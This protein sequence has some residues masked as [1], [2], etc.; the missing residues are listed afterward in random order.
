MNPTALPPAAALR[1]LA[2]GFMVSQA[3]YV[4][5]QLGLADLLAA[6]PRSPADLAAATETQPLALYRVLRLLASHGVFAEDEDGRFRLTPLAEPLRSDV[7]GSM[8]AYAM[9]RGEAWIWQPWSALLHGV[10]TGQVP[11]EH[12]LG[13]GL[14]EYLGQHPEAAA[15]FDQA[16]TSRSGQENRDIVASYDFAGIGRLVDV[17]G[18]EG[19][20]LASVLEA[21]PALQGILLDRPH[22][23][24]RAREQMAAR[25][26]AE[27]CECLAGDFFESIPAGADIYLLSNVIHDWSDD[28]A[29]RILTNCH[30]AMPRT[31]RLLLIETV[32]P[33]G[34]DPFPAKLIDL[35]MLVLTR[36]RERTAAEYGALLA[37]AG[38]TLRRTVPTPTLVSVLEAVPV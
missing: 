16:M 30:R 2:N 37:G 38:F 25:G 10:R 21:Y 6:G 14:F 5:A 34:N 20:L 35:Q 3:I 19:S 24:V 12:A 1:Q 28:D 4:A 23:A 9:T 17:G 36:G 13:V 7:P 27:R 11:A 33:P 18:G 31:G 29:T 8:R 15:L 32:I 26:L 22:A